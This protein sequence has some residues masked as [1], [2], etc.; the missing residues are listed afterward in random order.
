MANSQATQEYEPHIN[1]QATELFGNSQELPK[2]SEADNR[3][4]GQSLTPGARVSHEAHL[5]KAE[6]GSQ[7]LA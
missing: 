3:A 7:N 5:H 2:G 1:S 6:F 4:A